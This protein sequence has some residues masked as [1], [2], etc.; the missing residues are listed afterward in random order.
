MFLIDKG[1]AELCMRKGN[2]SQSLTDVMQAYEYMRDH[3]R[4]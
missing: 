3:W 2:A 4:W 1:R